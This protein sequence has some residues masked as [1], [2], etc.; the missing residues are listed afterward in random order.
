MWQNLSRKIL[1]EKK[2]NTLTTWNFCAFFVKFTDYI[3]LISRNTTYTELL[4]LLV[5]VLFAEFFLWVK[6]V[7]VRPKIVNCAGI[8][9]RHT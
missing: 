5:R 8:L 3:D 4:L 2:N 7:Y 1:N 6:N 9:S